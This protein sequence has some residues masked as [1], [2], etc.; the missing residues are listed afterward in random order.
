MDKC[1]HFVGK[2]KIFVGNVWMFKRRGN[3]SHSSFCSYPSGFRLWSAEEEGQEKRGGGAK[4]GAEKWDWKSQLPF[5]W[6]QLCCLSPDTGKE[7]RGKEEE[8]T[9]EEGK[10]LQDES[11]RQLPNG[12]WI[13]GIQYPYFQWIMD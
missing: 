3:D 10:A 8:R 12:I 13:N 1:K 2:S 9:E 5:V 7:R 4:R 11:Q 6:R